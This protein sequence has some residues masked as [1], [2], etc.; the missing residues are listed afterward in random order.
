LNRL[1]YARAGRKLACVTAMAYKS[2][3]SR[4][5]LFFKRL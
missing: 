2:K 5:T 1:F 4:E 3:K